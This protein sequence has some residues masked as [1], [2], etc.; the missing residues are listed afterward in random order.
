M[1]APNIS[2]TRIMHACRRPGSSIVVAIRLIPSSDE[3]ND[4]TELPWNQIQGVLRA[5]LHCCIS[6]SVPGKVGLARAS[7]PAC[8]VGTMRGSGR[9]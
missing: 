4:A 1:H 7:L 5:K 3:H 6:S 8:G 2:A 9:R